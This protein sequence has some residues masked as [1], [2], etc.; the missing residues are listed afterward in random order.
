[1]NKKRKEDIAAS[2]NSKN[3]NMNTLMYKGAIKKNCNVTS[4]K[5]DPMEIK[6][7]NRKLSQS[8]V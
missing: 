4:N 5:E 7:I 2:E 8:E 1:M 6:E 3:T